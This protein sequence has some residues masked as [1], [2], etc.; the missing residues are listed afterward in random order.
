MNFEFAKRLMDNFTYERQA[1]ALD[2]FTEDGIFEDFTYDFRVEGM[3]QLINL[4]QKFFDPSKSK[5]KFTAQSY[6]GDETGG[7][8]EYTSEM[9]I[10]MGEGKGQQV[11]VRGAAVIKLRDGKIT[12]FSDYW[13]QAG[14]LRQ[15]GILK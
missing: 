12:R 4:F 9:Q 14:V 2:M 1:D 15:I 8:I 5:F 6:I 13:D 7:A 11:K 3:E 10:M